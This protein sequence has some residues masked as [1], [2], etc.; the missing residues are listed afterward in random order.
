MSNNL[1]LDERLK[2]VK[3][4]GEEIV[5]EEELI[6]LLKEKQRP[7]AYDG[8]EPSGQIHI[9][10]GL[11]RAINVNKMTKAGFVFKMWVADWFGLINNKMGGDIEKI[12]TV[13][14]YF[15]EVWKSTGMDLENIQFIW[16]SDF[17]K[18]HPE[19]WELVL[20]IGMKKNLPRVL[21]TIEIMGR[22]EKDTL[23]AAQVIYPL[24]QAADIFMLE[25]DVAQLGMDQRKVNMLARE[26]AD[27]L[28]L[29]KPISVSHHML[30]G[31]LPPTDMAGE[32][33]ID[34]VI[35]LKMSKSKPDSA[36]FMTD[37]IEDIERKIKNAWCPEG[38]TKENPILEYCKYIVFEKVDKMHIDRAEK[39]GGDVEYASYTDLERDYKDKKLYPLDLK[40]ALAKYLNEFLEP[41][42]KYFEENE[43]AKRLKELVESYAVTR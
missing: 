26:V 27:D 21:R 22:S 23:T 34:K 43:E 36:I 31:L 35:R 15:I 29:T 17:I 39:F 19:Y 2:L 28:D 16:A 8:F 41:T 42:R 30:A 24:M 32:N 4:V 6:K 18:S 38:E 9:A 7:V 40:N 13:G 33:V 5:T 12:K 14:K 11:L 3:E 25:A 10:Q 1:S 37:N 20:K